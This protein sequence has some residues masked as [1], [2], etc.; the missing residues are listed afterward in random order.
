MCKKK[1]DKIVF[2]NNDKV[3]DFLNNLDDYR[4]IILLLT[5]PNE[6][7]KLDLSI[8]ENITEEEKEICENY[9]KFIE[10]FLEKRELILKDIE[11]EFEEYKKSLMSNEENN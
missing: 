1:Q 2:E 10:D 5:N 7:E 11:Q 3:Y 4:D 8:A 9:K 6:L